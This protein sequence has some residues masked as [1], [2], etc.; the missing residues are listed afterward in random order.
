MSKTP[1]HAHICC[2]SHLRLDIDDWRG[3][4]HAWRGLANLHPRK[5]VDAAVVR[6]LLIAVHCHALA[7]P[8]ELAVGRWGNGT[9]RVAANSR[10]LLE[11][12]Q[13]LGAEG[14]VVDLGGC[15][16][17]VLEVGAC[18]EVTE[19]DKLAVVLVLNYE[20]LVSSVFHELRAGRTVD[21]TPLSR[22][23]ANILAVDNNSLLRTNNGE[24]NKVLGH[25]SSASGIF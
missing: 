5:A 22:A 3:P 14:L 25:V 10:A 18:Q 2:V 1:G 16:D 8:A 12:K 7:V 15:L 17:E 6:Q 23:A 13:L 21:D 20:E 11:G 19:V 24:G 9:R 4:F